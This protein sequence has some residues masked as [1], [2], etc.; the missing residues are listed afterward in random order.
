MRK[1]FCLAGQ[2]GP[3]HVS[4]MPR[5]SDSSKRLKLTKHQ[6]KLL[7]LKPKRGRVVAASSELSAT[8]KYADNRWSRWPMSGG[9]S[10]SKRRRH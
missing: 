4:T 1:S 9:Q 10:E 5:Q 7:K 3:T 6:R 8:T 2:L